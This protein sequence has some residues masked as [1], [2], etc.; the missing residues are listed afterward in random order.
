MPFF[1]LAKKSRGIL[2]GSIK[3]LLYCAGIYSFLKKECSGVSVFQPF[4]I[5][6]SAGIWAKSGCFRGR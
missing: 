2:R 1:F 5:S 3:S 6:F 4:F